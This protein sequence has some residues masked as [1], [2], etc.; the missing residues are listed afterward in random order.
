MGGIVDEIR[1]GLGWLRGILAELGVK[2]R[3]IVVSGH[4]SG[5][6]LCSRMKGEA[7]L[8]GII[9]ISGLYDLRLIGQIY[10]NEV[11]GLDA[12]QI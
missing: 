12:A 10:V 6:H 4:S 3:D 9:A 11:V 5:G 2:N 8:I 7:G 1:A